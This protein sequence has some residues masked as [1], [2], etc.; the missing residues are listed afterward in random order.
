MTDHALVRDCLSGNK[1]AQK[2]LYLTYS[3]QMMSVCRR[4]FDTVEEAEDALQESFIKVFEKLDQWQGSGPLGGWIRMIVI[5]TS[6][7]HIRSSK[8]RKATV[9][10]ETAGDVDANIVSPLSS[11]GAE[12]IHQLISQMPQGY[13][14]VFNLFAV[15]GFGHKEIGELL[16]ITESTSK[17]Q[18]HKA[19]VW[20][21]RELEKRNK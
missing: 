15:E 19:R 16:G 9:D 14:T 20:I 10:I 1:N 3:R 5:N 2:K 6:L 7:N 12:E 13:R 4:Y 8:Q 21:Q 17:T 11:M 18:F